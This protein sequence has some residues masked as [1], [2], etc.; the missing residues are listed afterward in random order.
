MEDEKLNETKEE[1]NKLKEFMVKELLNYDSDFDALALVKGSKPK[2]FKL[3]GEKSD[4]EYFLSTVM[5]EV[6]DKYFEMQ[7][8][9]AKIS[10]IV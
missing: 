6:A 10:D 7:T 9:L 4:F 1:L 8:K 2:F 5:A 3:V